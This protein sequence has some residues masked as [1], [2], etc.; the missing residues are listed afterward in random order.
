MTARLLFVLLPLPLALSAYSAAA[1]DQP[2]NVIVIL[3]DDLGNADLSY[4][5]CKDF[6]TPNIDALAK[7]G[8]IFTDAH[9]TASVCA[10]SR[11]GLMSGKYQQH[12]GFECNSPGGK[13]GMPHTVV[14]YADA[15]KD[16]GYET[17]AL[18]KWHLGSQP[19]MHPNQQGF[20]HFSG[21]IG[22]GRAYFPLE[23]T[24][25]A[26][27]LQRN[28]IQ[29]PEKEIGFLTNWL[30]D[31]ALHMIDHRDESKPFFM[32]LAYNAPHEP[33]Q[34]LPEDLAKVKNIPDKHRR[35]YAALVHNLDSNIGKLLAAL[36]QSKLTDN[37]LIFF[38]SDN[39]GATTN[40]SDNGIYRGMKGSKWEGG[41]RV[42]YIVRWP[43]GGISG[44]K[45]SGM[46][47]STLDFMATSLD[48]CG[49]GGRIAELGLDGKSLL[50]GLHITEPAGG[51]EALFFRRA[52]AAAV[53]EGPWKL[54]RVENEDGTFRTL[55]FN[56]DDDIGETVDLS[57]KQSERLS[58]LSG[59]LGRWEQHL[60]PPAWREGAY[61]EKNQRLKHRL[62]VIGREA[63]RKLP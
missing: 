35:T 11:A 39:G 55:L 28:G 12:F 17:M 53:R 2:P 54:I 16:A 20:D 50:P 45:S 14:T 63:E 1:T 7:R 59:E 49:R 38:A 61:W 36:D 25:P 6:Q 5:G 8:V 18:G 40:G 13:N 48:A 37:T 3:V 60:Q 22:G 21:F 56:L 58:A 43:A 24:S 23:K 19:E 47:V 26:S 29:V 57:E 32:Y 46:L 41:H 4:N 34:A 44:G 10:P 30:T 62:G 9:A 52:V 33:I 15:M 31:E 42:P 27:L 51:H